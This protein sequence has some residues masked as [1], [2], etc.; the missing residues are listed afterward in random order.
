MPVKFYATECVV[1]DTNTTPNTFSIIKNA[2][3]SNLVQTTRISE[4][5]VFDKLQYS[6]KSFS[7]ETVSGSYDLQFACQV[8][9]CLQTDIDTGACGYSAGDCDTDYVW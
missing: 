3:R 8:Q 9:F 4:P 6:Y 1:S 2:C 7:F 5:Y